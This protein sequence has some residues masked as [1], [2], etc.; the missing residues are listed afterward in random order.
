MSAPACPQCNAHNLD[1]WKPNI[2]EIEIYRII[3][4]ET[5]MYQCINCEHCWPAFPAGTIAH[6]LARMIIRLWNEP[7][8]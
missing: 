6:Q 7:G 2:L 8:E 1:P 5:L 3:P 4:Y